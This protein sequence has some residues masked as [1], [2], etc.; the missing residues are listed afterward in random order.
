MIRIA[1]EN[2]G[3]ETTFLDLEN[4]DEGKVND[5]LRDNTKV[6]LFG[7]YLYRSFSILVSSAHMDRISHQPN[8]SFDRYTPHRCHRKSAFLTSSSLGR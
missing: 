1:K 2:Q 8:P 5:A 3:L 4:A 6:C 7:L